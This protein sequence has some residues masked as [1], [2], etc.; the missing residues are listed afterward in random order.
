MEDGRPRPSRC[1]A[2]EPPA[3]TASTSC[4]ILSHCNLIQGG[5]IMATLPEGFTELK[6]RLR[7]TWMA[8]DFGEIAKLNSHGAEDFI[9]RLH[10]QPGT[11]VLDVACGTGK[12]CIPAARGGGGGLARVRGPD[13]NNPRQP[14]PP[15]ARP[16]LASVVGR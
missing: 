15:P 8:G 6:Q 16:A 12:Q 11:K 13:V 5:T 9:E 3:A 1:R 2:G 10:L 7:A 14:R 4:F